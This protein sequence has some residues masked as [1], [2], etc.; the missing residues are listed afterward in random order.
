MTNQEIIESAMWHAHNN[1]VN[2]ASNRD[3]LVYQQQIAYDLLQAAARIREMDP[4]MSQK[5]CGCFICMSGGPQG[6]T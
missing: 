3:S 4:E 5:F 2:L 6:P 1:Q